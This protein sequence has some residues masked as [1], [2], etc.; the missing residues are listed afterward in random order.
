MARNMVR[1]ALA[2]HESPKHKRRTVGSSADAFEPAI[3]DL[4]GGFPDMPATVIAERVAWTGSSS[5]LRARV[6]Y[7]RLFGALERHFASTSRTRSL[8]GPAR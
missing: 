6:S 5:V 1:A 3:R 4:L 2:A 8:S 7:G